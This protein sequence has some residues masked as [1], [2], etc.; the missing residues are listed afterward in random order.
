MLSSACTAA[1]VVEGTVVNSL[2][3][4]FGF[5]KVPLD[6]THSQI[7][8]TASGVAASLKVGT[9]FEAGVTGGSLALVIN[10]TDTA[11]M[12]AWDTVGHWV[13]QHHL[14][15]DVQ[16][17]VKEMRHMNVTPH[18]SQNTKRQGGNAIDGRTTRHDGYQVSQRK[19]KRIEEVFGW[20]K[21]VAGQSQTPSAVQT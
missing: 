21:T 6:A 2:S 3:G 14:G 9:V 17:F 11:L 13:A 8:A 19:R 4:D 15:Q 18:V 10:Q 5:R 12:K 1:Q 16:D 20:V 7:Q